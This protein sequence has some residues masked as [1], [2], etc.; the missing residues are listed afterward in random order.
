MGCKLAKV[1]RV[2]EFVLAGVIGVFDAAEK[3]GP[4]GDGAG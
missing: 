2:V 1:Y 3:L 4:G